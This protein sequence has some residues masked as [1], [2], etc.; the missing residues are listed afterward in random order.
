VSCLITVSSQRFLVSLMA[1]KAK[2]NPVLWAQTELP[3]PKTSE[4]L[5]ELLIDS[6][7]SGSEVRVRDALQKGADINYM[8]QAPTH[9][10]GFILVLA[11]FRLSFSFFL[12]SFVFFFF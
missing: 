4:A 9:V 6:V 12:F 1:A 7:R 5:G 11:L 10:S 3:K 2:A 8:C